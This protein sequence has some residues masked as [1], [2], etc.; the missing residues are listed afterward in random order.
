M[1][2]S[3]ERAKLIRRRV[4]DPLEAQAVEDAAVAA[5]DPLGSDGLFRDEFI[6]LNRQRE[7]LS[8]AKQG[9][10]AARIALKVTRPNRIT[11]LAALRDMGM[12]TAAVIRAGG[13]ETQI[14]ELQRALL[15]MGQ[16]AGEV[17]RDTVFSYGPRNPRGER[18][19][20][21]TD[22]SDERAF[23][24][25]FRE[26]ITAAA[27]AIRTLVEACH[28][29]LDDERFPAK[30][31]RATAPLSRFTN[32]M[33]QARKD[34][35]P[36][37]FTQEIRPFLEIIKH[38]DREFV[39]PGG[40]Q[41]PLMA[42]DL[43]LWA[44]RIPQLQLYRYLKEN[45]EYFP[46]SYRIL[47][48]DLEGRPSLLRRIENYSGPARAPIAKSLFALLTQLIQFRYPHRKVTQQNMQLRTYGPYQT[49]VLDQLLES[50]IAARL[51]AKDL[52]DC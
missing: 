8:L 10:R 2:T 42:V 36:E 38:K 13:D 15:R 52:L 7:T 1:G 20:R 44:D 4:T 29:D 17:P 28:M 5:A 40:A 18:E 12:M 34:I 19:R 43:M 3:V 47:I 6:F 9:M 16:V 50:T 45:V 37:V 14:Q 41:I 26:G 49:E 30:L 22:T 21:F 31:D 11:A 24:D 32:A 51:R 33:I 25:S 48:A 27:D 35:R 23:I 46:N 39:A